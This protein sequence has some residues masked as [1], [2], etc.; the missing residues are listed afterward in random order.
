[1]KR[2]I[3]ISFTILG[4]VVIA[5]TVGLLIWSSGTYAPKVELF[6]L[7]SSADYEMT[8][9]WIIF[10]PKT[11]SNGVG[12]ILYP[13]ALVEPLAYGYYA[14][15]LSKAGYLVTILDVALNMAIFDA[16]KAGD[17]I[18]AHP[19]VESWYLA[20]HS[21]GGVAAAM[22]AKSNTD[23][24][25]GLIFLAS[26]PSG[27]SDLSASG[28]RVLSISSSLDGLTLSSDIENKKPLLPDDTLYYEIEGGNHAGFGL[29]GDQKGDNPA[30]IT[31]IE[32]QNRM[33][34]VTL[35]FLNGRL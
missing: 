31:A 23:Q 18:E 30:T 7:V 15:E 11:E 1:M 28:L 4:F 24:I 3:L 35:E 10:N 17:F 8:D 12:I 33:I 22:F 25:E 29:Y 32:Q 20:G 13:G 2:R 6:D 5:M 19:D 16:D 34:A 26:Y 21:I 27:S 9:D 14:N